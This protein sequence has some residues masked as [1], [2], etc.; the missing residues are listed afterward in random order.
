[1]PTK[2]ELNNELKRQK[3]MVSR[4]KRERA[5]AIEESEEWQS[6]HSE[7][8]QFNRHLQ[9]VIAQLQNENYFHVDECDNPN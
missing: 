7:L 9:G 6:L 4:L 8:V 1:M 3:S 5:Q 2:D